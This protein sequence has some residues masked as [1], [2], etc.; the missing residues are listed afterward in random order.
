MQLKVVDFGMSA[1]ILVLALQL[2]FLQR[3]QATGD[4]IRRLFLLSLL[5]YPDDTNTP[6]WNDDPS[7]F[8]A[9]ELAVEHINNRSDVLGDYTLELIQGDSGCDISTKTANDFVEHTLNSDKQIVGIMGLPARLLV[10][11]SPDSPEQIC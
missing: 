5:P 8:L 6:A 9:A 10:Q 3:V 1:A 2:Y 7:L 11:S 4:G